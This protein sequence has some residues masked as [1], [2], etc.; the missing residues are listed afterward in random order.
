MS[1]VSVVPFLTPC[2]RLQTNSK[3][4]A[5]GPCEHA[6]YPF[7]GGWVESTIP[8]ARHSISRAARSCQGAARRLKDAALANAP[9]K[10]IKKK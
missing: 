8:Q 1:A 6:Q 7:L 9:L 10:K 4:A 3:R 5:C 2:Q